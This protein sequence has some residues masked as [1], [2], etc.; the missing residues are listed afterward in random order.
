MGDNKLSFAKMKES[1]HLLIVKNYFHFLSCL[2]KKLY[3]FKA[4]AFVGNQDIVI[5]SV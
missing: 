5:R 4:K 1:I 2:Q 3:Y